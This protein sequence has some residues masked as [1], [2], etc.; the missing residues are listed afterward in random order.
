MKK[1]L[2]T[3]SVALMLAGMATGM[4]ATSAQAHHPRTMWVNGY[5]YW[6]VAYPR[7]VCF[8]HHGFNYCRPGY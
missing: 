1:V 8:N 4:L 2:L 7:G 3:A 5:K 6:R